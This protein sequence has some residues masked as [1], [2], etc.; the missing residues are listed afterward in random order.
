MG[1]QLHLIVQ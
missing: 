1:G